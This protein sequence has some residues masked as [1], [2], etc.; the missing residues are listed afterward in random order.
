M[1]GAERLKPF[2]RDPLLIAMLRAKVQE[3]EW[4]LGRSETRRAEADKAYREAYREWMQVTMKLR[5]AEA[6]GQS[7]AERSGASP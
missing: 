2:G 3:A 1:S 4:A 7:G 6:E 5:Q